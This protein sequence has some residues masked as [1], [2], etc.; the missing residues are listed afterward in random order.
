[1]PPRRKVIELEAAVEDHAEEALTAAKVNVKK[2][3]PLVWKSN[4]EDMQ[5]AVAGIQGDA[6]TMNAV[7]GIMKAP[8]SGI[9]AQFLQQ[10]IQRNS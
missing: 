10:I 5:E 9:A 4:L 8:N 3:L 7:E 6:L 2:L 1:M